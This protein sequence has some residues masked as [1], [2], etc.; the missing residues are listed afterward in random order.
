MNLKFTPEIYP[1][2]YALFPDWPNVR[3]RRPY[4]HVPIIHIS[5]QTITPKYT[6]SPNGRDLSIITQTSIVEETLA[7]FIV[8]QFI[9]KNAT[10]KQEN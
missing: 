5:T 2:Y 4:I 8:Y 7:G 1:A 10:K 3:H 6:L 9:S